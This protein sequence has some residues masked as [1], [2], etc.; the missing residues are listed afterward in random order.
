MLFQRMSHQ[1][2]PLPP[3]S[4]LG[5]EIKR[6]NP[7][8][9]IPSLIQKSSYVNEHAFLLLQNAF[10]ILFLLRKSVKH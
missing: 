10:D 7:L 4:F 1:M 6:I 8:F 2:L 3:S 5:K 9:P